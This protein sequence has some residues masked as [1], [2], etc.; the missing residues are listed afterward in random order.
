ME[1]GIYENNENVRGT[2]SS[3]VSGGY[4]SGF[5]K[6]EDMFKDWKPKLFH[7]KGKRNVRCTQVNL[8]AFE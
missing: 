5:E 8:K 2:F 7:C 6:V 3:Y 1:F 4:E